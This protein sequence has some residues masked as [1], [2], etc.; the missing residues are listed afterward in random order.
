MCELVIDNLLNVSKL[1][2]LFKKKRKEKTEGGVVTLVHER[3]CD[4]GQS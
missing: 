2:H 1:Y 3:P 4:L